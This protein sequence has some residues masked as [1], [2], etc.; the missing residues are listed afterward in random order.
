MGRGTLFVRRKL[1]RSCEI[2]GD[3]R[4]TPGIT[5]GDGPMAPAAPPALSAP[6][7]CDAP[8]HPRGQG[9]MEDRRA[10]GRLVQR[11]M[12]RGVLQEGPL[13]R[14]HLVDEEPD[15]HSPADARLGRDFR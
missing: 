7:Y 2:G 15:R 1:P 5:N 14:S 8:R 3:P 6:G 4:P 13:D 11:L 12:P 10:P 9:L